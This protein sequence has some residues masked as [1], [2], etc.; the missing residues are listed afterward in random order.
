MVQPKGLIVEKGVHS[1]GCVGCSEERWWNGTIL[2]V[3]PRFWVAKCGECT[4][5]REN[6]ACGLIAST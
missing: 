5:K 2:G 6:Y 3:E 1:L 4:T